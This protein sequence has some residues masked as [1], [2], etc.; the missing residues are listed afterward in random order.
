M[1]LFHGSLIVRNLTTNET[2]NWRKY[3]HMKRPVPPNKVAFFNAFDG[4]L[5][6]NIGWRTGLV[7]F[8]D[9]PVRL[10]SDAPDCCAGGHHHSHSHSHAHPHGGL[11][12]GEREPMLK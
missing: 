5:C 7:P 2:I 9:K 11:E 6:R 3:P 10:P 8:D 12:A 4:G 1:V